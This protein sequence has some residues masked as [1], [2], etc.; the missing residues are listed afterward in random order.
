MG[1]PPPGLDVWQGE[2][3]RIIGYRTFTDDQRTGLPPRLPAGPPCAAQVKLT[4][5]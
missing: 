2:L 5:R 4:S 3:C 1:Q